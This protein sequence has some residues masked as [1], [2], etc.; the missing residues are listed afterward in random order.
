MNKVKKHPKIAR[1]LLAKINEFERNGSSVYYRL[2]ASQIQHKAYI[3]EN[4][5]VC[6]RSVIISLKAKAAK[7]QPLFN[8]LHDLGIIATVS[9]MDII[10]DAVHQ[11]DNTE[12]DNFL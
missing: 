10:I 4:G 9:E 3:V 2:L 12:P 1:I 8:V 6:S 5:F 11:M 7:Y